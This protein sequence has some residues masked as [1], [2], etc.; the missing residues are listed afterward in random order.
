MLGWILMIGGVGYVLSLLVTYLLPDA[1]PVADALTV[2]A[3]IGEFWIFGYLI[4]FGV[5]R[6]SAAV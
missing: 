3:S 6:S 4:L 1:G 2:P 5:R